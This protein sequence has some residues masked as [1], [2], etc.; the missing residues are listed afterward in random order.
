MNPNA[1]ETSTLESLRKLYTYYK[2]LGE[3]SMAQVPDDM[4]FWQPSPEGNSIAILVKHLAGNMQ[5]RFKDFL[6]TDGEKPSRNR[7]GEFEIDAIGRE[8]LMGYWEVGWGIALDTL[9]GLRSE[10]M[11]STV[12]IRNEGHLVVEA[13]HRQ[14]GHY[15]YHVGQMVLFAR[16]IVRDEWTSLSIPKG[17]STQF[18]KK[19]FSEEKQKRHFTDGVD[20]ES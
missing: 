14:L 7:D 8:E 6:T 16:M 17:E 18:N 19:K 1:F 15:A 9:N 11:G 13:L 5:S 12:Y 10:D 2:S 20:S 4:L 3:K